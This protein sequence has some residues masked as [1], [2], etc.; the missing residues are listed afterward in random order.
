MQDL[1]AGF[2]RG[3]VLLAGKD[4]CIGE[5][6]GAIYK[7]PG[8]QVSNNGRAAALHKVVSKHLFGQPRGRQVR[9]F[10]YDAEGAQRF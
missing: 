7:L 9:A 1:A 3:L 8:C 10:R 6:V 4:S 5:E 2:A